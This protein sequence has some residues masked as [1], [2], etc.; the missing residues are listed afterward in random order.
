MQ[1]VLLVGVLSLDI[2]VVLDEK[3]D[4]F[5]VICPDSVVECAV[6]SLILLKVDVNSH[7]LCVVL[8]DQ[9]G[10]RVIVLVL[11]CIDEFLA[12]LEIVTPPGA[13]DSSDQLA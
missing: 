10:H 11:G 13:P 9:P 12:L 3:I 7:L 8:I 2:S 1:W 4:H 6:P 5:E